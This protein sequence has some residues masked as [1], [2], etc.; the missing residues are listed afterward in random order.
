MRLKHQIIFFIDDRKVITNDEISDCCYIWICDGSTVIHNFWALAS[1]IDQHWLF[2]GLTIISIV[3][4]LWTLPD[5]CQQTLALLQK[6]KHQMPSTSP[7]NWR[8]DCLQT[9]WTQPFSIPKTAWRVK[10]HQ[11]GD[12]DL[13]LKLWLTGSR[14]YLKK[15]W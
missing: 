12:I 9:G 6:H 10:N 4:F 2:H 15:Y 14:W 13:T 11:W 7:R 1:R 3:V 5:R 8:R